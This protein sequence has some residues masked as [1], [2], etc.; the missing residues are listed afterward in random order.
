MLQELAE[1]E[2]ASWEERATYYTTN[3]IYLAGEAFEALDE[4]KWS[5]RDWLEYWDELAFDIISGKLKP[6]EMSK[7]KRVARQ[8]L[9]G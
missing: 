3:V 9:S 5:R 2:R 4:R 6:S 1:E 7:M 8:R